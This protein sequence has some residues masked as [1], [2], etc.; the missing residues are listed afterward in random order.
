MGIKRGTI[1]LRHDYDVVGSEI[2]GAAGWDKY[3]DYMERA[4]SRVR[5]HEG[6]F[7]RGRRAPDWGICETSLHTT[8]SKGLL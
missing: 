3:L 8:K 1:L 7:E 5:E 2:E 4:S 6:G